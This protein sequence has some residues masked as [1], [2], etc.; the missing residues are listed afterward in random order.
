MMKNDGAR[1]ERTSCWA[2][3]GRNNRCNVGRMAPGDAIMLIEPINH[4]DSVIESCCAAQL[5][6]LCV[7]CQIFHTRSFINHTLLALASFDDI[8]RDLAS[9]FT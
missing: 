5:P 6:M 8:P 7:N 2:G 9:K 4:S 1:N 3:A